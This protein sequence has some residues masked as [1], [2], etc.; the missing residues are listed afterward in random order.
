MRW[1]LPDLLGVT[2]AAAQLA[3]Y[4]AA[5]LPAGVQAYAL[6]SVQAF[7]TQ[8]GADATLNLSAGGC[9]VDDGDTQGSASLSISP[10]GG[11]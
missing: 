10:S 4:G 8:Y 11:P 6:A 5:G 7:E 9:L 3:L 2:P 1:S